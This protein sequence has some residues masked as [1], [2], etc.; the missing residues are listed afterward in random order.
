MCARLDYRLSWKGGVYKEQILAYPCYVSVGVSEVNY[1]PCAMMQQQLNVAFKC[2]VDRVW[3][4]KSEIIKTSHV[5]NFVV[6]GKNGE[7]Q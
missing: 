7:N 4:E 1:K 3:V 2:P 6:F 5:Q